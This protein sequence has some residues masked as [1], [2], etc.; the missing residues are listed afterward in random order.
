M[1]AC[2]CLCSRMFA[3]RWTHCPC[4]RALRLNVFLCG[5]IELRASMWVTHDWILARILL[6]SISVGSISLGFFSR[7]SVPDCWSNFLPSILGS[8]PSHVLVLVASRLH[9]GCDGVSGVRNAVSL[10]IVTAPV[11]HSFRFLMKT[12]HATA[13]DTQRHGA[14]P[15]M[16]ILGTNLNTSADSILN[17]NMEYENK[18]YLADVRIKIHQSP[19]QHDTYM[20]SPGFLPSTWKAYTC[21]ASIY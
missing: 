11:P 1:C 17:W 12:Q 10:A 2:L 8:L 15:A 19:E 13:H 14:Q 20:L 3:W 7:S 6:S 21:Q 18:N 9:C 5:G 16:W 4:M